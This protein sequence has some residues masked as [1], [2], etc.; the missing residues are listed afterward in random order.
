MGYEWDMNGIQL[1]LVGFSWI[2]WE[3]NGIFLDLREYLLWFHGRFF[4]G[5]KN[6]VFPYRDLG[7][8]NSWK[9]V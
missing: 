1:G 6:M 8:N 5:K 3:M 4:V 2:E 7:I 9:E